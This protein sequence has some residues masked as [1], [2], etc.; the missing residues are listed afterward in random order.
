MQNPKKK[1]NCKYI[2]RKT[3]NINIK[4]ASFITLHFIENRIK[5]GVELH[6]TA[7]SW[8][9]ISDWKDIGFNAVDREN[10]RNTL[11]DVQATGRSI[12]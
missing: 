8:W 3:I 2:Q 11:P 4:K 1:L 9:K 10:G 5:I 6:W 12:R 7:D